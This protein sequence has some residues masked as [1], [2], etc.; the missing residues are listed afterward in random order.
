VSRDSEENKMPDSGLK[1]NTPESEPSFPDRPLRCAKCGES[2]K[3][4]M[5]MAILEDM[6]CTVAPSA[7]RCSDG[8]KHDLR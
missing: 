6:G 7:T 3:A 2:L 5:I 4:L 1:Q 8:G